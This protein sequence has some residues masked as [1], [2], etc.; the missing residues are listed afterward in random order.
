MRSNMNSKLAL[1]AATFALALAT[2]L[3]GGTTPSQASANLQWCAQNVTY[4]TSGD[5]SYFSFAQCQ[6][7]IS[8]IGGDCIQNPRLA[9]DPF[10]G[11]PRRGRAQNR[12][13]SRY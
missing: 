7:A 10:Y 11:E 1:A 5:C 8:G 13:N 2:G 9:Y 12:Q 6:A 3:I 4:N